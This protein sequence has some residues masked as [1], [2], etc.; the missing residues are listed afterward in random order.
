M[1]ILVDFSRGT[2]IL[3]ANFSPFS[4][5]N[6]VWVMLHANFSQ[7]TGTLFANLSRF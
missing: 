1:P 2:G 3:F 6:L 4:L 5:G 7:G